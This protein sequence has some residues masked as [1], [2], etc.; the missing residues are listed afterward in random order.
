MLFLT[1]SH[2]IILNIIAFVSQKHM[3]F[4]NILYV[5]QVHRYFDVWGYNKPPFRALQPLNGG[6]VFGEYQ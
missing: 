6:F 4:K 3:K 2:A 1:H 5:C